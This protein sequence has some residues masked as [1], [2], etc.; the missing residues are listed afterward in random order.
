MEKKKCKKPAVFKCGICNSTYEEKHL[1]KEHISSIHETYKCNICEF[2]TGKQKLL[3]S[4]ITSEHD[5]K[6][7]KCQECFATFSQNHRFKD[8][9]MIS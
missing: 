5:G 6:N 7:F 9:K 1:L 8:T 3:K 2:T 4:H